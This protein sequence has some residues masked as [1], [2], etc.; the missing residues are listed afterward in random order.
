MTSE[1]PSSDN[2][3]S[4]QEVLQQGNSD[5]PLFNT[6]PGNLP[7]GVSPLLQDTLEREVLRS[8]V[9]AE[10]FGEVD[11][12][13][14]LGRFRLLTR[15]GEGG[16]GTVYT[17][18]DDSLDRDVA[19]KVLREDR[20]IA[21][22]VGRERLLREAKALASISHT[23]VVAVHE[24]GDHEGRLFIAMELVRGQSLDVWL[25]EQPRS[26]SEVLDVFIQAATGLEAAHRAGL[27]H[28]DFKPHNAILSDTGVVKVLDFGLVSGSREQFSLSETVD[29]NELRL[30][31]TGAMLG[32]PAY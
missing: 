3:D 19:V 16:M 2:D 6:L 5:V 24:V 25:R 8:S 22:T 27:V 20:S 18:R 9:A 26:Y 7:P 14:K 10:L 30:T 1:P 13:L 17:A 21:D 29:A 23:N 28:R 11:H 4:C 12:W 15:L 32:T 31:M